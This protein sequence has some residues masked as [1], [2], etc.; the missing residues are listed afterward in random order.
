ME[1][2]KLT[3]K[4]SLEL[5][6]QMIRSTRENM[7]KGSGNL[8]LIWGYLS[9]FVALMIYTVWA[10]TGN[11]LIF[12]SWWLIPIIG[13]P[14][15]L[16]MNRKREKCV[17]TDINRII[18]RVWWIAGACCVISPIISLFV[19]MPIL[20]VEALIINMAVAMMGLIV[21]YKLITVSGCIGIALSYSLLFVDLQYQIL[22]F[23]SMFVVLMII[24]GHLLNAACARKNK[25]NDIE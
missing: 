3:E 10:T 7:E 8:F 17:K 9:T 6:S 21:R 15:V 22:I 25:N 2:K 5:I 24:P 14:C 19:R 20:F 23:A 13:Y 18:M 12:W 4:E 1:D 11:P 16:Y